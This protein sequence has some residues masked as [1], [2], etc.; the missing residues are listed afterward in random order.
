MSGYSNVY[1]LDQNSKGGGIMLF[2]KDNLTIFPVNGFCYSEKKETF[3]GIKP[4]ETKMLI[5]CCCNPYKHLI[6]DHLLRIKN[7]IDFY[8]KSYEN[9]L[10]DDFT[11]R[12]LMVIWSL[13]VLFIILKV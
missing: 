7:E 8:S 11:W 1:R 6:K 5:F 12:F 9:I 10:I 13:S 4:Q 2:V 3:R